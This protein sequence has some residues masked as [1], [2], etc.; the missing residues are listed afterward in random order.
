MD[1][2]LFFFLGAS[3]ASFLGLVV[4]RFPEKSIISPA[5]HCDSCGK[6]LEVRDLIPVISQLLNQSRCRFCQTKI[7][8]W[9]GF[10]EFG[11]GVIAVLYYFELLSLKQVFILIFSTVLSLYDMK[12][13]E[14][15]LL[16]W[17]F[18]SLCLLFFTPLNA[19]AMILLCL[20]IIAELIDLKIGSGDFFYLASLS[21]LLDLQS[22]LWI[23]ELGSL[24]G[25][26]YCLFQKNKR[27]PFI[28]FLFLGYV[29]SIVFKH[30]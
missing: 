25:I 27:I 6:Q 3:I 16:I 18:P 29:I 23:V 1:I 13:Q 20:G 7:P 17:I 28:P 8:F 10:L 9:Y 11:Y 14:F 22:I 4:E 12:H 15:P 24:S 19:L 5:S 21:L 30:T 2:L 26:I